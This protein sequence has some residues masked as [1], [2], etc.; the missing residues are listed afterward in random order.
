MREFVTGAVM[1]QKRYSDKLS[2]CQHD[3]ENKLN[4]ETSR[5][6]ARG[7]SSFGYHVKRWRFRY[8]V[9]VYRKAPLI[10]LTGT[11]GRVIC[12]P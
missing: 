2:W 12:Q 6:I 3:D 1:S 7:N 5:A 10:A 8:R 11:M 9:N 4:Q